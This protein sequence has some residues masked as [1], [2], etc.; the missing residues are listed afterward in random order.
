MLAGV[1]LLLA[2]LLVPPVKFKNTTSTVLLD[3]NGQLLSATV[4]DEGMWQFPE[5][6]TVPEKFAICL[7]Q[8]EDAYFRNH[9]GVNPVSV[10]RATKQNIQARRIV[11]GASTITMQLVR[12]SRRGKPRTF[13]EK[14][15]EMFLAV[16]TEFAFSKRTILAKYAS[17]APFG[18]NVVGL[19]A[20]AWR[21]FGTSPNNL[22]W[23]EAATLAI[24]PNAPGLIFPGRNQNLLIEK[25]NRLLAKLKSKG[26]I[27]DETYQLALLEPAPNPANDLPQDATHLLTRCIHDGLKGKMVKST[28][29]KRL[30]DNAYGI[31]S[32]YHRHFMA[33]GIRNMAA[34]VIDNRTSE[35]LVYI[36][37]ILSDKPENSSRV[38]IIKSKRSYGSLLKPFLYGFMLNEGLLYP[39]QLVNDIPVAYSDFTPQ[40]FS[41]TFEGMV[42]AN[43]ILSRS[44]N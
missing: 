33:N 34:M 20:A 6:D 12:L 26:Y 16:R 10:I 44:L 14:G 31:T 13:Y 35:V 9:L 37:N 17:Q 28:I 30:Y 38:D 27:D 4:S 39:R 5:V 21:Y 2:F 23:A 19:D 22:S 40:N 36:G 7:T 1:L 15:I 42:S 8:F 18:G 41:K 11:S 43:E 25:R 24:L 29:D 3:R 32:R